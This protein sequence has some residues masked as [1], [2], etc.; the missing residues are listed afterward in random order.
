MTWKFCSGGISRWQKKWRTLWSRIWVKHTMSAGIVGGHPDG[1]KA[2]TLAADFLSANGL[3]IIARNS[4]IRGGEIDL[5]AREK[6]ESGEIIVFVEVRLR[7][8]QRFGGAAA[9][10]ISRKRRR[11]ILAAQHWLARQKNLSSSCRFDCILLKK[12]D[13]ADIEWVKH[14]FRADI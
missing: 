2:E 9:S 8:S 5:I 11:I 12:L 10:I 4:R 7:R 1:V 3:R 14:A 6:T 13:P